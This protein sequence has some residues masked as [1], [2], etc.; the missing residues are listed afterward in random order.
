MLPCDML[1]EQ[2]LYVVV[3]DWS[4]LLPF[5][6]A[7]TLLNHLVLYKRL[8]KNNASTGA[9]VMSLRNAKAAEC[10][11]QWKLFL[12]N[13]SWKGLQFIF[14]WTCRRIV[15]HF[16]KKY[17][18]QYMVCTLYGDNTKDLHVHNS[19]AWHPFKHS[20]THYVKAL[21]GRPGEQAGRA[22]KY[23]CNF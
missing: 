10:W 21:A 4:T 16:I 2:Q 3:F 11:C 9:V 12:F 18:T 5:L 22:C 8:Y 7:L 6:L 14:S 1:I 19:T 15:H 20:T 23:H 17:K 13:K